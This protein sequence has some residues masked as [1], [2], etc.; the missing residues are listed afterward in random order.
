VKG[1]LGV[2]PSLAISGFPPGIVVPP[3]TIH[4]GD[5]AAQ[6]AQTDVTAAFVA[7]GSGSQP[8]PPGNDLTGQDLGGKSLTPGVYC[9]STSAQL[10]GALTLNAQGNAGA[11]FVFKTGS[12]LTTASG[13]R[14]DVINGG[15][16]CLV[17]WQIGSSATL[18]TTTS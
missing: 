16:P 17:A 13:S 6:S 12:T 8:C 10:T 5:A 3:G 11:T 9:F 15:N 4:A 14:V 1:N 7:I 2:W 18:G